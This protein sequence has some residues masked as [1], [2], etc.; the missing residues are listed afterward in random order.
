MDLNEA[1]S[2]FSTLLD[3]DFHKN[4][5]KATFR[6]I[7]KLVDVEN[8]HY[9]TKENAVHFFCLPNFLDIVMVKEE[10]NTLMTPV[11]EPKVEIKP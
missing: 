4:R 1:K 8:K 2:F 9:V 11:V 6:K 3:L 7:M 5:H 10:A